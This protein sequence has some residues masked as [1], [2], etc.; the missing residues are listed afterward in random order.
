MPLPQNLW[1]GTGFRE[2]RSGAKLLE[3]VH[4]GP[5]REWVCN[6]SEKRAVVGNF[7]FGSKAP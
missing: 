2:P 3:V 4:N 1:V 6:S 7:L 5:I